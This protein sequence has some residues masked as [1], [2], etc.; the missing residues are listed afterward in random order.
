MYVILTKSTLSFMHETIPKIISMP[1]ADSGYPHNFGVNSWIFKQDECEI[2]AKT[3]SRHRV[4]PL[5]VGILLLVGSPLLVCREHAQCLLL[6]CCVSTHTHL[7]AADTLFMA[8]FLF[9]RY[10]CRER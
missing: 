7:H 9:V 3:N 1:R 5:L 6:V 10:D 2:E 8:Q 4:C